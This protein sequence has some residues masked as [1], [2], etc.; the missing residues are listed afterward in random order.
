MNATRLFIKEIWVGLCNQED[1]WVDSYSLRKFQ[2]SNHSTCI[3]QKSL[4]YC[5]QRVQKG[6][7]LADGPA[8]D[9]GQL[10][11][12]TNLV[13]AFLSWRGYNFEDSI[14]KDTQAK[15]DALLDYRLADFSKSGYTNP[16]CVALVSAPFLIR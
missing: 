3:H 14:F 5:G 1:L 8:T 15:I 13:V 11:L 9:R 6:D 16:G 10:A 2:K 12:G 4:V 7:V